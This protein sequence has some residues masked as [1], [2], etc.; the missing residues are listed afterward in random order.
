MSLVVF[1]GGLAA[2]S[3][4]ENLC[5][6]AHEKT[7]L[8]CREAPVVG[9][10][11]VYDDTESPQRTRTAFYSKHGQLC[12]SARACRCAKIGSRACCCGGGAKLLPVHVME[13]NSDLPRPTA[14][15][16]GLVLLAI[17]AAVRRWNRIRRLSADPR[18]PDAPT[19]C[20]GLSL[21]RRSSSR[22]T[23]SRANPRPRHPLACR[24]PPPAGSPAWR[25]ACCASRRSR[26]S[27]GW[28]PPARR[29][30]SSPL[31]SRQPPSCS[32]SPP[33]S[34]VASAGSP[35]PCSTPP[36]PPPAAR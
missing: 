13:A 30:T 22:L 23:R 7:A 18:G 24:L 16:L 9:P 27:R 31:Y 35:P 36:A 20:G 28:P 32:S 19:P 1:F 17:P 25:A 6:T 12:N 29:S 5:F 14:I 15:A 33:S 26:G 10:L 4:R 8:Y 34:G 21:L 11:V 2:A 3:A